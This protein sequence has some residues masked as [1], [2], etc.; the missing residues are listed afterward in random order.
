MLNGKIL[1]TAAALAMS[2][3][4][5]SA[6]AA[7]WDQPG[8]HRFYHRPLAREEFRHDF[9]GPIMER[10]HIYDTLRFHHY[11]WIGAPYFVGG[12]YVVRTINPFGRTVLI[13]VNPYNG[14]FIGEF[15][16]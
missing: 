12:H 14:A 5:G 4:A 10:V 15:R 3:L 7:P 1:L 8:D 6:N 16:I 9:R 13:E 11:R 2:S